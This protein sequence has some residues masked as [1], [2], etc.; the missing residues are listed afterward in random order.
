MLEHIFAI[1]MFCQGIYATTREGMIF[2]FFQKLLHD[3]NGNLLSNLLKVIFECDCCMVSYW[4]VVYFAIFGMID[5]DIAF[6]FIML[7]NGIM[8][9]DIVTN[10]S[11]VVDCLYICLLAGVVFM[12]EQPNVVF[13][14]IIS[15]CGVNYAICRMS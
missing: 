11:K 14:S 8:F 5:T 15:A 3:K 1:A 9:I 6:T 13:Y 4:G 12:A 10:K 2:G 7:V